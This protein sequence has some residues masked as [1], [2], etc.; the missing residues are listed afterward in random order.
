MGDALVS[1]S[2]AMSRS[3]NHPEAAGLAPAIS[4]HANPQAIEE[5]RSILS[6][7]SVLPQPVS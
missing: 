3:Q 1:L 6:T 2:S 4:S 7:H 5:Q